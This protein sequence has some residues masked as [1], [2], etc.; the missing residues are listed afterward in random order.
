MIRFSRRVVGALVLAALI[1][2]FPAIAAETSRDAKR[3]QKLAHKANDQIDAARYD[4]ALKI[5]EGKM[6]P[7]APD[8]TLHLLFLAAIHAQSGNNDAAF[9]ALEGMIERGGS[10][11]DDLL[12]REDLASLGDD[13]RF[14]SL[15]ERMEAEEERWAERYRTLHSDLDPADAESFDSVDALIGAFDGRLE[16]LEGSRTLIGWREYEKSRATILDRKLASLERFIAEAGSEAAEQAAL[17]VVRTAFEYKK[18][19]DFYGGDAELIIEKAERFLDG[20][21]DSES[22][23]EVELKIAVA[24]WRAYSADDREETLSSRAEAATEIL[25]RLAGEHPETAEAEKARIWRLR[26]AFEA[27]DG[28]TTPEIDDL[29]ERVEATIADNDTLAAYAWWHAS[30]PMFQLTGSGRLTVPISTAT[31]GRGTACEARSC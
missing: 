30:Q 27:A 10:R 23:T 6:A 1:A 3:Y 26:I 12:T 19:M 8:G 16:A 11:A 18:S 13:P 14:D 28:A 9:A 17:E 15:L 25:E 20:W 31:A 21:P 7:L 24:T 5:V 29:F 22:S 4:K 2:G